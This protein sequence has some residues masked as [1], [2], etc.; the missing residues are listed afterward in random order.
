M[1]IDQVSSDKNLALNIE[2]NKKTYHN[3]RYLIHSNEC[4][5]KVCL[6]SMEIVYIIYSL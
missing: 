5:F 4:S 1:K 3:A 6:E 2:K